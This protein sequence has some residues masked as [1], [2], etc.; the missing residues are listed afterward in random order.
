MLI[1]FSLDFHRVQAAFVRLDPSG[2]ASSSWRLFLKDDGAG[3]GG[4]TS[5][6]VL[7]LVFRVSDLGNF[8]AKA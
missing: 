7:C 1:R 4:S 5:N 8:E 3:R 2:S 6:L